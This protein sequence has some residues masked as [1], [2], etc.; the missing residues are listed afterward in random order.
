MKFT[1]AELDSK[2]NLK[3]FRSKFHIPKKADGSDVVYFAGNSLGLQPKSVREYVE[4]ELKDWEIYGVEGHFAA[5]HPWLPYHEYLTKK[6]A[7]IIGAKPVEVVNMNSLTVNLHLMMVSFYRP[8]KQR[9]K[10]LIEGHAFPSDHYA[11]QSQIK[12][13]GFNPAD[14]LLEIFPRKGENYVRTEDILELIEREGKSI[15]LVMLAGVNY[16][17]GQAFEMEKITKAGHKKGCVVGFDLAH[18]AGNLVMNLHDWDVDFAVWCSYKYLNGGPGTVGG[19]FVHERHAFNFD[20]PQFCGWW[21][22]DKAKRFLMEPEYFPITGVERW[23][24]SNPPILQL[25]S[26]RASLDIFEEASIENLRAKS[27]ALTGYLEN[28]IKEELT[29]CVEIITPDDKNQRGCQLSLRLKNNA[30][31]IHKKINEEGF[32]CDWREPD[33][34]RAAPVPLYNTFNDVYRFVEELKSETSKVKR[35]TC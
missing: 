1:A 3:S 20:L 29:G 27:E 5:K 25:A 35:Q 4:Q 13:H 10:I 17:T 23:Q 28:L 11:V 33:V 15:A 8:T 9:H 26:L 6:T 32:I 24:L 31:E 7:R 21:G 16:Y 22:Q 30:R 18:A 19:C 14:S 34:I 12:F 2:D